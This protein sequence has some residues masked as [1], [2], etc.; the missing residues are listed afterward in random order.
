VPTAKQ[1]S[2][3]ATLAGS[4]RHRRSQSLRVRRGVRV[5]ALNL[6]VVLVARS[7]SFLSHRLQQSS[8][9]PT[10]SFAA[11]QAAAADKGAN[12]QP[13]RYDKSADSRLSGNASVCDS[14]RKQ[15]ISTELWEAQLPEDWRLVEDE[16]GQSTYFESPDRAAGAYFLA[17]RVSE[18][19]LRAA[20]Q[21]MRDIER[22]A[23]P[24][25]ELGTWEVVRESSGGNGAGVDD[26][27]EYFNRQSC[28]RIASRILGRSSNCVRF[29]YHDYSCTEFERSVNE[30][31]EWLASLTLL[32]S[33]DP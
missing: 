4:A 6:A 23:L 15:T 2:L 22:R 9:S 11:A 14:M 33:R 26:T 25:T 5:Q 3:G 29:A 7:A 31:K 8:G 10:V 12:A 28:Y 24:R 16:T 18:P 20:V 27:V 30:S 17:W 19:S 32:G 13:F 21:S 1:Q